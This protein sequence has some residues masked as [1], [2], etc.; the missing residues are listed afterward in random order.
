ML[1]GPTSG[2]QE[3]VSCAI[4]AS[5]LD[6]FQPVRK[7]LVPDFIKGPSV[8]K[9]SLALT[10]MEAQILLIELTVMFRF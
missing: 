9:E 4:V 1:L 10:L 8:H 6:T 2:R 5:G 3:R 7:R